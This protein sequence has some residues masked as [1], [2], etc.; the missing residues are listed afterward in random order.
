MDFVKQFYSYRIIH[1]KCFEIEAGW[2]VAD[3][4]D[5]EHDLVSAILHR[6]YCRVIGKLSFSRRLFTQC[7][8][9]VKQ[10]FSF[11]LSKYYLLNDRISISTLCV[12]ANI[13]L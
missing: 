11:F 6:L 13:K 4:Y 12:Q 3:K 7:T 8:M 9:S 1:W 2:H 10:C 5:A